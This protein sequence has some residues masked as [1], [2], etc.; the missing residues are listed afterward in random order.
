MSSSLDPDAGELNVQNRHN[1]SYGP[2]DNSDSASDVIGT[3]AE[4]SDSDAEGTGERVSI[5]NIAPTEMERDIE[6]DQVISPA[7]DDAVR[8]GRDSEEDIAP[9]ETESDI[10]TDTDEEVAESVETD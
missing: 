4:N 7:E 1:T 6:P 5:E 3:A 9:S 8:N 2:S 10:E